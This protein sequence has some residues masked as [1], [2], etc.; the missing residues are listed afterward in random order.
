[1]SREIKKL[2]LEMVGE[3]LSCGVFVY[4]TK[5]HGVGMAFN[6]G[7][8]SNQKLICIDGSIGWKRRLFVLFHEIGHL[9]YLDRNGHLIPRK[10]NS[11]ELNANKMAVKLLDEFLP[12]LAHEYASYY[13]HVNRKN[14]RAKFFLD[15]LCR[16]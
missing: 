9:F 8:S 16:K 6:F 12:E 10:A 1:M 14:R 3:M 7:A 4:D 13:N 2:Y 5:L 11:S 15:Q